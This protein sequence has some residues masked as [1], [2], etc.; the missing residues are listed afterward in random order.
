MP[1]TLAP[2]RCNLLCK[3]LGSLSIFAYEM[4]ALSM[5]A[6]SFPREFVRELSA[7]RP[8]GG[9]VTVFLIWLIF[10]IYA[11]VVMVKLNLS[12]S[13]LIFPSVISLGELPGF[14]RR[15]VETAPPVVFTCVPGERAHGRQRG[16]R[17][18]TSIDPTGQVQYIEFIEVAACTG[19][20]PCVTRPFLQRKAR[21]VSCRSLTTS[22]FLC[23]SSRFLRYRFRTHTPKRVTVVAVMRVGLWAHRRYWYTGHALAW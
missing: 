22:P 4:V 7:G 15:R 9:I 12:F 11:Y 6:L 20:H 8:D 13:S 5:F 17:N 18:G 23:F 3:I 14:L 1:P 16:V 19:Y 10:S 21:A 2:T